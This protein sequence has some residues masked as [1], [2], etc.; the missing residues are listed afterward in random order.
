VGF[1]YGDMRG[2]IV[3]DAIWVVIPGVSSSVW[4]YRIR[5]G[6]QTAG[7]APECQMHLV[8]PTVSRLHAEIEHRQSY[9]FIRDCDSQ[10]GTFVNG[11]RVQESSFTLGDTLQLGRVQLDVLTGDF[12][13][14]DLD[15]FDSTASAQPRDRNGRMAADERLTYAQR[16]V[17]Q[18]LLR[19]LSE[20]DIAATSGVTYHTVHSHVKA[21]YHVLGISSRAALMARYIAGAVE[22]DSLR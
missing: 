4:S 22:E 8:H 16:E 15:E 12:T 10:N 18:L 21:I 5:R 20:S 2:M 1:Q 3:R 19:G 9:L 6:R 13:A 14:P 7:R 11:T 17:L